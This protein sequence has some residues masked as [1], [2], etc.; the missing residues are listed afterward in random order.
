LSLWIDESWGAEPKWRTSVQPWPIGERP[1]DES[2]MAVRLDHDVRWLH[3]S[4]DH[5]GLVETLDSSRESHGKLE[6]VM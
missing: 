3:V 6:D 4:M 1:V 5:S 2:H